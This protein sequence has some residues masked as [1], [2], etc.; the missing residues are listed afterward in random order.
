M[1][2]QKTSA[3]LLS[4]TFAAPRYKQAAYDRK[5]N[6]YGANIGT[7][8]RPQIVPVDISTGS[9]SVAQFLARGGVV[10]V[11]RSVKAHGFVAQGIRV[12]PFRNVPTNCQP[13]RS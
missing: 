9:E 10:K 4:Y 8:V 7:S 12:K 5:G 11:G 6:L 3:T 2:N 1:K 13:A